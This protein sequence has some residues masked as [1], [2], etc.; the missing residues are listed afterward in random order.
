MFRVWQ[1]F[2][3]HLLHSYHMQKVQGLNCN[4][5]TLKVNFVVGT[6]LV[7]ISRPRNK[8]ISISKI[9]MCRQIKIPTLPLPCSS[10]LSFVTNMWADK[11]DE[12]LIELFIFPNYLN[13]F[14]YLRFL[15]EVSSELL[16]DVALN[17]RQK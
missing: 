4:D 17:I 16:E 6:Y 7:T 13:R 15:E 8:V 1:V 3:Q 5:F 14:T 9:V 2:Y 11:V 10:K 12:Y